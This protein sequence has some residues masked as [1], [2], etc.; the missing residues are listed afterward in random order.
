MPGRK[1]STIT[2]HRPM[3]SSAC[4]WPSGDWRSST[5]LFL[6]RLKARKNPM[7]SP[8]RLRVLSPPGGSIL[9][10]SAPRSARI[11]PQ[12]GPITMCVNSITRMPSSGRPCC[13]F[14]D[15]FIVIPLRHPGAGLGDSRLAQEILLSY[16]DPVVPE[17]VV[18]RRDVKEHVRQNVVQQIGHCLH[19]PG[20]GTRLPGDRPV[21]RTV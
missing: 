15:G 2:S 18:G 17:D 8:G 16:L 20:G 11:I 1:F 7:P 19:R 12:V 3:R 9:I 14:A 13:G 10:T 21:L 6:L 5:T 4:A